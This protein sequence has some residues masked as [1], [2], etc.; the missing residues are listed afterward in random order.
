M[1]KWFFALLLLLLLL[2]FAANAETW[3]VSPGGMTIAEALSLCADGDVVELAGGVY[4][5]TSETFPLTVTR[6]VTLCAAE[7]ESPVIDVPA[8][9]TGLRVEAD[10][11]TVQG[12]EIRLRRWGIL[13]MGDDMTLEACRFI[14]ADPAWRVS[15]TAMWTAG[16]YRMTMRDC[17][18]NGCG[19]CLAGPPLRDNP[20]GKVAF[21]RLFEVGDDPEYFTTHT[22]ENCTVNGKPLFYAASQP[23]VETPEDA[24]QIIVCDCG[25]V[26]VRNADVS[27]GSIGVSLVHN[28][29]VTL[30][31]CRADR[32]GIF[33]LYVSFCEGGTMTDCVSTETNH[34]FDVRGCRNMVLENCAAIR[35]EQ[36]LFFSKVYDS[37]MIRC[38]A[39]GTGQGYF[40][41]AGGGNALVGCSVIGCEN[42]VKLQGEGS[43]LVCGCLIEGCTVCG[44]R[45]DGTPVT[46]TGNTLRANWVGV[47]AYGGAS[48]EITDNRFEESK[49]CGLYLRDVA[50]SRVCGNSFTGTVGTSAQIVGKMNGSLWLD[51]GMDIPADFS[52]VT[53]GFGIGK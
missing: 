21:T 46:F 50:Y 1:K 28:D 51:N 20:E 34:G 17:A 32:C 15:S 29:H 13:A 33:G 9:Q 38:V 45:L 53:D 23:F 22:I 7:G 36:G 4:D 6:A 35:C 11:V 2:P 16:I 24:G 26:L 27:D 39:D 47:M 44:V 31:N 5:E 25:E 40:M 14:L 42:G 8:M 3:R 48:Y 10:G 43:T 37:A 12:V 18:F 41:A 52:A 19:I 30:E 49:S